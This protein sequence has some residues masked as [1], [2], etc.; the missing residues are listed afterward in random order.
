MIGV[1][2]IWPTMQ[3]LRWSRTLKTQANFL[4]SDEERRRARRLVMIEIH[5]A[6]LLPLLAVLM[7]R[8]IGYL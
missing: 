3:F 1:L 6:A 4:P 5:L 8:G 7:A 2:S